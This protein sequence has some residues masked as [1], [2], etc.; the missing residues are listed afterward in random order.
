MKSLDY[1]KNKYPDITKKITSEQVESS[2]GKSFDEIV[3]IYYSYLPKEKAV[4]YAREAFNKNI[5][6]LMKFGGV[7]YI[8]T[9]DTI[10]ELSKKYK[11]YIIS[12]CIDGY[13]ESFLNTSGLKDYFEDYESNGRTGLSK[14]ENIKLVIKRNKIE[15]AMYVGDTISDKQAADLANIPFVYASYGFGNVDKYD[16]KIG[17]IVDLLNLLKK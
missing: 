6:N 12:N 4:N 16:Y 8:N 11:L 1:V 5:E 7:L 15:H 13:I 10:L 3:N 17:D 14:G 9:K 2:M